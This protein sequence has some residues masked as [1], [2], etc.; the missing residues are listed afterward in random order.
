MNALYTLRVLSFLGIIWQQPVDIGLPSGVVTE[1]SEDFNDHGL[2][3][4]RAS[5]TPRRHHDV[6]EVVA[7]TT[8]C[9]QNVQL[10]V[11]F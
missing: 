9:P 3:A 2:H 8:L 7:T 1:D 5:K 11:F 6:R 10:F 4:T